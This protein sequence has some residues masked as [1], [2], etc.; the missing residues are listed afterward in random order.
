[1]TSA[2]A[3]HR[4]GT[5]A[6][7]DGTGRPNG[8]ATR[9][10]MRAHDEAA[11]RDGHE[12]QRPRGR[13]GGGHGRLFSDDPPLAQGQHRQLRARQDGVPV[14]QAPEVAL[15][16]LLGHAQAGA[17]LVVRGPAADQRQ[18]LDLAVRRPPRRAP[19]RPQ[20]RGRERGP[21]ARH[22]PDRVEDLADLA[23][24]EQVARGAALERR[25]DERRL[26]ERREQ[27]DRRPVGPDGVQEPQALGLPVELD[28]RD[29]DVDARGDREEGPG[30]VERPRRSRQHEVRRGPHGTPDG[31]E[32]RGVVVDE[33][34]ADGLTGHER[35][36]T[37]RIAGAKA[38]VPCP[39]P[40]RDCGIPP[41]SM[42]REVPHLGRRRDAA[43]RRPRPAGP[44]AAPGA[45]A[46]TAARPDRAGT[47]RERL[48]GPCRVLRAGS[49]PPAYAAGP[50]LGIG[51]VL[52][53]TFD[54]FGREWSL[55]LVLATPAAIGSVLQLLVT[56]TITSE[57][58]NGLYRPAPTP[59]LLLLATIG[60]LISTLAGLT[61]L[62]CAVAAD[63]LWRG[64]IPGI[65]D[66]VRV[67]V[68]SLPR[69][70]PIWLL[71]VALQVVVV[72]A[73]RRRSRHRTRTPIR[74]SAPTP[75]SPGR[76]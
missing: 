17:D 29:D 20:H 51:S 44:A 35:S 57:I 38:P 18:H 6:E 27:E 42:A 11:R 72:V 67:V 41:Y 73:E 37:R 60:I 24:L 43:Q 47:R 56:P 14:E 68:R 23:G 74:R 65:A 4:S 46:T 22:G 3:A 31:I 1:M 63:R 26:V 48:P 15:D 61:G 71:L 8:S 49:L 64:E 28:V 25:P 58:V 7:T 66:T 36:L 62:A 69:A 32:D 33:H 70:I 59:N 53:R 34:D 39:R 21:A 13:H 40:T 30:I 50:R 10:T 5:S 19:D 45:A 54:T 75:R 76:C 12:P 52:G 9:S 55:F 2:P 16:G